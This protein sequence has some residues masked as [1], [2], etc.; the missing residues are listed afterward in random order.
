MNETSGKF[1]SENLL[2]KK[3]IGNDLGVFI[4]FVKYE[5][6]FYRF[7]FTFYNY[8]GDIKIYK[9]SFDDKIDSELEEALRLYVN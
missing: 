4:Y 5:R 1:V 7:I 8:S 6:K 9:Y 3:D 2:R